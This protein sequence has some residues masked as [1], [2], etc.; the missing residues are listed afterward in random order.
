M[1]SPSL[2]RALLENDIGDG[3]CSAHRQVARCVKFA[4][5]LTSWR[6]FLG[7]AAESTEYWAPSQ[8]SCYF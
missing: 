1:G 7:K 6:H 8:N 2:F 4:Q 5:T 3:M